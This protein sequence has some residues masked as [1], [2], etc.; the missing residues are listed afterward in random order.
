MAKIIEAL[1]FIC[2]MAGAGAMDSV[3]MVV[4]AI[5]VFGGIGLFFIGHKLEDRA[6]WSE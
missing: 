1:G 2:L 6:T 4:P 3:S 5:A